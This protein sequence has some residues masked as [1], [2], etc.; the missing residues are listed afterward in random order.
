MGKATNLLLSV[1]KYAIIEIHLT[2]H[3]L[4]G[5]FTVTEFQFITL[6]AMVL[7]SRPQNQ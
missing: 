2:S 7:L 4:F 6:R 5:E 1:V 3:L